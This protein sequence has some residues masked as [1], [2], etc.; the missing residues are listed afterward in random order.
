MESC[1][2]LNTWCCIPLTSHPRDPAFNTGPCHVCTVLGGHC[3]YLSVI[4][5]QKE[6]WPTTWY[7]THK[8]WSVPFFYQSLKLFFLPKYRT[9][10]AWCKSL[11]KTP[12]V[13]CL[14]TVGILFT[15]Y[16][17]GSVPPLPIYSY[18]F[19]TTPHFYSSILLWASKRCLHKLWANFWISVSYFGKKNV[20]NNCLQL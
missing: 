9:F 16:N 15:S 18:V 10:P 13:P 8:K 20:P 4:P 5:H 2:L 17:L 11:G 6:S 1:I 12:W 3:W 7:V 19:I 14:Y